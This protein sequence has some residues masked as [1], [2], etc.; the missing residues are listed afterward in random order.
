MSQRKVGD[1][2]ELA[3][4][5]ELVAPPGGD[6]GE[7]SVAIPALNKTYKVAVQLNNANPASIG[8]TFTVNASEV[9][10]WWPVGYGAPNLYDVSITYTPDTPACPAATH[11]HSSGASRGSKQPAA[12]KAGGRAHAAVKAASQSRRGQVLAKSTSRREKAQQYWAQTTA[13]GAFRIMQGFDLPGALAFAKRNT[14]SLQECQKMCQKSPECGFYTFSPPPNGFCWLKKLPEV[15][16]A[17]FGVKLDDGKYDLTP[18][19]NLAGFDLEKP[20]AVANVSA[21]ETRCNGNDKCK[22][23]VVMEGKCHMKEPWAATISRL[24]GAKLTGSHQALAAGTPAAAAQQPADMQE[25]ELPAAVPDLAHPAT[26]AAPAPAAASRSASSDAAEVPFS[27]IDLSKGSSAAAAPG[28][29]YG[30]TVA[31]GGYYGTAATPGD[32]ALGGYGTLEE[33]VNAIN[34]LL[35]HPQPEEPTDN[36]GE[37]SA[38][39]A[40]NGRQWLTVCWDAIS[41]LLLQRPMCTAR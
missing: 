41:L 18:G 25:E 12:A 9:D 38:R 14:D 6:T 31:P 7:L 1:M 29:H 5:S 13:D 28:G 10:L 32:Y 21:C 8:T 15:P 22:M 39:T 33:I 17:V 23:F 35:P 16:G 2:F 24:L 11:P 37:R 40:Q 30:S 36:A 3:I 4:T 34:D 20:T 19:L 27:M 26:A